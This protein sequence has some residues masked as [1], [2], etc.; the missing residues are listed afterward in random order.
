MKVVVN[1][2]MSDED[3]RAICYHFGRRGLATENEMKIWTT[4]LV[5]SAMERLIPEYRAK[6]KERRARRKEASAAD[7]LP[8]GEQAPAGAVAQMEAGR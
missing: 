7:D 2:N 4:S 8:G 3:R 5:N 1:L 6:E